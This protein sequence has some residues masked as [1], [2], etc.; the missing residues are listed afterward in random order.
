[1]K[2]VFVIFVLF[3]LG[4]A[5]VSFFAIRVKAESRLKRDISS[6]FLQYELFYSD[7]GASSFEQPEW[8][9]VNEQV[10]ELLARVISQGEEEL[11]VPKG[12]Y[13]R[14]YYQ[15]NEPGAWYSTYDVEVIEALDR[16]KLY[17][18]INKAMSA[19]LVISHD[20]EDVLKTLF[21]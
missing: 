9:I 8:T 7:S 17:I 20:L 3:I 16:G 14:A 13:R 6:G 21:R 11:G 19:D 18:R 1:M 15:F 2:R 10:H 5:I 12:L 4:L